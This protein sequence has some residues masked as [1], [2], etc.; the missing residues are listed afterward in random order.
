MLLPI[1][2][3]A[4]LGF[5]KSAL[6]STAACAV[7]FSPASAQAL[8][9]KPDCGSLARYAAASWAAKKSNISYS[10]IGFSGPLRKENG[11]AEI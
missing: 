5:V 7:I 9:F 4:C 10:F 1:N 11:Y 6:F 3:I 2:P 8:P